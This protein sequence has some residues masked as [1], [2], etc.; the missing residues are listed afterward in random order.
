[1][2][3]RSGFGASGITQATALLKTIPI[4]QV[5]GCLNKLV[6]EP[7]LI[8]FQ[9]QKGRLDAT[10]SVS[11]KVGSWKGSDGGASVYTLDW[12]RAQDLI[13]VKSSVLSQKFVASKTAHF[14]Q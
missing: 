2:A 7:G 11:E 3:G 1:M 6:S 13:A 8:G 9:A 4:P 14:S 12:R 5:G 10:G